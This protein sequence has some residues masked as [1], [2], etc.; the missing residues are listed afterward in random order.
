MWLLE[1]RTGDRTEINLNLTVDRMVWSRL[2]AEDEGC[3]LEV[4]LKRTGGRCPFYRAKMAAENAH[5]LVVNHALL[6]A[7]TATGNRVLPPFDYLIVDEAHHLESATT[8]AMSFRV[9]GLD[10][11]RLIRE[12]GGVKSG[13][14]GRFVELCEE[15]LEPAQ[16]ATL[17]QLVQKAADSSDL[18]AM[19]QDLSG[20]RSF[21]G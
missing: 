9:R 14:L 1:S 4:C 21:S 19:N 20:F 12:L 7:D 17:M 3:R 15:L 2:S 10:I 5:L 13:V 11:T 16:M 8:N 18:I 6:L